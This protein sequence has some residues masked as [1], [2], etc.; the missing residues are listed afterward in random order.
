MPQNR[1]MFAYLERCGLN[2][3]TLSQEELQAAY[4]R[5]IYKVERRQDI[6]DASGKPKKKI[7][8]KNKV[9]FQHA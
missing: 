9:R 5:H 2:V 1:H 8:R 4:Y 7:T 6:V 3:T